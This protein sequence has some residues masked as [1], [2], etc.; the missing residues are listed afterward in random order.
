M[1]I[2]IQIKS[3]ASRAPPTVCAFADPALPT[4]DYVFAF[5]AVNAETIPS[6][7]E[8]FES[9]LHGA[10]DIIATT[11]QNMVAL[12]PRPS[13]STKLSC[14]LPTSRHF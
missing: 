12:P 5:A 11:I 10:E 6:V 14:N 3:S 13:Q 2:I 9:I 7:I 1:L 8:Q 4:R